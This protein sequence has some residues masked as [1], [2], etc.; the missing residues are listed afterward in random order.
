MGINFFRFRLPD[1]LDDTLDGM[2]FHLFFWWS[3]R[4]CGMGLLGD[5][6]HRL[7]SLERVV[8]S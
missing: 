2:G 4:A 3:S 8:F 6:D 7:V 1:F 5:I